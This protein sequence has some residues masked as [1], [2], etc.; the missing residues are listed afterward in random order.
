MPAVPPAALTGWLASIRRW[1]KQFTCEHQPIEVGPIRL[2]A[3]GEVS[4]RT[5]M[6][7]PLCWATWTEED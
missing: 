2:Q 1:L 5:V 7:C 6:G 4:E 3:P